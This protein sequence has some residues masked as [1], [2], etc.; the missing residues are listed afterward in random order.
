M[1][2]NKLVLFHIHHQMS[3]QLL[4]IMKDLSQV[5]EV[6]VMVMLVMVI[7]NSGMVILEMKMI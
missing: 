5:A 7:V 6:V 3:E 4:V 2:R 1:Q